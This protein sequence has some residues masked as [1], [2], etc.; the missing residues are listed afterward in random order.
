M[1]IDGH[2]NKDV[3]LVINFNLLKASSYLTT[4]T[5]HDILADRVEFVTWPAA[6]RAY[7]RL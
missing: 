3:T 6:V 4:V 5:T 2:Q 7:L 1:A